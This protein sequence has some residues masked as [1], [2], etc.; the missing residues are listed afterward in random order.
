MAKLPGRRPH[1]TANDAD[2]PHKIHMDQKIYV[3][4]REVSHSR[5]S[6]LAGPKGLWPNDLGHILMPADILEHG[7]IKHII[8]FLR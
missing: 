6:P 4:A 1:D 5:E 8:P 2:N 3:T 7:K